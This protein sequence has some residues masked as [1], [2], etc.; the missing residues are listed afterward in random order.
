MRRRL[1][2]QAGFLAYPYA[3][4]IARCLLALLCAASVS[5]AS[6]TASAHDYWMMPDRFE[7]AVGDAMR[8]DLWLG[9]QM[10]GEESKPWLPKR[11]KSFTLVTSK[12]VVDL[13]KHAKVDVSP[14]LAGVVL[15]TEGPAL[16]A[17]ER[18]WTDITL[19]EAKFVDYLEHEGLAHMIAVREKRG[20]KAKERE[21]YTRALKSLVQV[22][23][24]AGDVHAKVL[25]HMIEIVL[26]DDPARLDPGDRQRARL[27]FFGKPLADTRVVAHVQGS[28][29]KVTTREARTDAKGEVGFDATAGT[30]LLRTVHMRPCAGC[31]YAEWES[32]W[33]SFTFAID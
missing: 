6:A 31:S 33:T 7:Y 2:P 32:F 24:S 9:Q 23:D 17:M 5:L 3:V 26:V 10:I 8:L 20:A 18:R 25:G 28:D 14:V 1:D 12:G 19:D 4:R 13:T 21:C 27:L 11:T 16:V 22:G 30:W 29:G 15:A